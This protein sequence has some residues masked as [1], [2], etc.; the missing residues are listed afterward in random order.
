MI[1]YNLNIAIVRAYLMREIGYE[2]PELWKIQLESRL[3]MIM[4]RYRE[5]Y[6]S[7]LFEMDFDNP[8]HLITTHN[9]QQDDD[10]GIDRSGVK[11]N[12][13]QTTGTVK[14]GQQIRTESDTDESSDEST[15]NYNSDFPQ[16]SWQNGDYV[17]EGSDGTRN[18]T[19]KS[20][21]TATQKNSGNDDTTSNTTLK[22]TW[23]DNTKDINKMIMNYLHDVKGHSSNMDVLNAVEKWRELIVNIN[24][25]IVKELADLFMMIYN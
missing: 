7:T 23:G 24:E 17:S 21:T 22:E 25:M 18:Q 5:L 13:N 11:D 2:T 4:P 15:R 1:R 8:Y 9:E 16:A 3:R 12:T 14:Y 6:K 10:R 20:G 19:S